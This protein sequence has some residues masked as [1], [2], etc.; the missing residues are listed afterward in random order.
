MTA[1][2]DVDRHIIIDHLCRWSPAG[3]DG[4]YRDSTRMKRRADQQPPSGINPGV[5]L[6][7]GA[8]IVSPD[9]YDP[10]QSQR[11][12]ALAALSTTAKSP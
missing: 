3:R 5:A 9:M 4:A 2:P 10:C 12:A 7:L 8:R 6:G 1:R 11:R